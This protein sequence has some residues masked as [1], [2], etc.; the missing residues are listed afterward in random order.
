MGAIAGGVR[1]RPRCAGG[2]RAGAADEGTAAHGID[3]MHVGAVTTGEPS[4]RGDGAR[5]G[6]GPSPTAP[7]ASISF[8]RPVS[9]S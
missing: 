1:R 3:T 5:A 6:A 7:Q 8:T 4:I 9:T 2:R